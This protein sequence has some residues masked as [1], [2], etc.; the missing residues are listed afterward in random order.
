MPIV[1]V[2]DDDNNLKSEGKIEKKS[3]QEGFLE[4]LDFKEVFDRKLS[5]KSMKMN[6]PAILKLFEAEDD[7]K[8]VLNIISKQKLEPT[9]KKIKRS[10]AKCGKDLYRNLSTGFLQSLI[11]IE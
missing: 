7:F 2:Q 4:E 10:P 11:Q 9:P 8:L 6:R 5:F 3:E 1:E